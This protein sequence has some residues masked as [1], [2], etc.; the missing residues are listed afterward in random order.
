VSVTGTSYARVGDVAV[1]YQ[2]S[3]GGDVDLVYVPGWVSHVELEMENPLSRS[4]YERLGSFSRLIR[5][6]KRGTGMSD[7]DLRSP[8]LEERIADIG[9]VMDA[10]AS[11]RAVLLGFSEGGAMALAF[12][13]HHP[14]RVDKLVL[15]ASHAGRVLGASDFPCGREAEPMIE[16]MRSVV[17][18]AWGQ[19]RTLEH[20]APSMWPLDAARDYMARFER[21][22]A[23]PGAALA[24]LEFN[25]GNDVRHLLGRVVAP[26]LVLQRRGDRFVPRCN[27]EYLASRI[28]GSKLVELDGVDHIPYVGDVDAVVEEV[29]R[30]VTAR[31]TGPWQ[32]A[33]PSPSVLAAGAALTAAQ[34]R[35]AELVADGLTNDEI[36]QRLSLSRHTVESHLKHAFARLGLRSRVELARVILSQR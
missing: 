7:R 12:A 32:T 29:A 14:E 23:T 24:H 20:L 5:F 31:A 3:G 34:R 26:T 9:A 4:F 16:W 30:F 17:E 25:L 13:A 1:A 15:F 35:V 27:G 22:A 28:D 6:D 2:V 33:A 21:M 36:A 19:G 10:V 18:R 11:D 8:S